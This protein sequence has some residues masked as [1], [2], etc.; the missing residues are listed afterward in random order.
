M[1][2]DDRDLR[3]GVLFADADL[4]GIPC[5]LTIGPRNLEKGLLE[6]KMRKHETAEKLAVDNCI[7]K[8]KES[9]KL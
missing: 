3:V 4:L 7:E 5:R 2:L 9:I 1:L 6:C 8:L